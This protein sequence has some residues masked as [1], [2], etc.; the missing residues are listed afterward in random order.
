MLPPLTTGQTH[1]PRVSL[2][3]ELEA[4]I[5]NERLDRHAQNKSTSLNDIFSASSAPTSRRSLPP[6][7]NAPSE[8]SLLAEIATLKDRI[9]EM[10]LQQALNIPQTLIEAPEPPQIREDVR[11]RRSQR[12]PARG[13]SHSS[14]DS[15]SEGS[16]K[17]HSRNS[18]R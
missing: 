13:S 6:R 14:G 2:S 10:N 15:N 9:R 3:N 12:L 7:M 8:Q 11:K 5:V 18:P 17:R 4:Y 16:R 1:I